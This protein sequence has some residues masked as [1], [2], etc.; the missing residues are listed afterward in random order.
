MQKNSIH[1]GDLYA[2]RFTDQILCLEFSENIYMKIYFHETHLNINGEFFFLSTIA[3][4][5][6]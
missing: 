1:F 6:R 5:I 2:F 4:G 3:V